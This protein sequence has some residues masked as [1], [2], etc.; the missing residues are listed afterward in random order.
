[1]KRKLYHGDS[2][3]FMY[4]D[5][6]CSDLRY[7]IHIDTSQLSIRMNSGVIIALCEFTCLFYADYLGIVRVK[8]LWNRARH[9]HLT[10]ISTIHGCYIYTSIIAAVKR[11]DTQKR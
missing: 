4:V 11:V 6:L 10:K 5:V 1:M 8:I 9:S 2:R 3:G 7:W